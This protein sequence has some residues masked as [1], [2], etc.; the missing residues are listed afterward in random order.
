MLRIAAADFFVTNVR[1]NSPDSTASFGATTDQGLR[2]LSGGQ[3]SIQVEG[4]LAIQTGAAP[5]LVIDTAHAVRD[6]SAVVSEAPTADGSITRDEYAATAIARGI[7]SLL[8]FDDF[9]D[10]ATTSNAAVNGF[11]LAPLVRRV[12]IGAGHLVGAWRAAIACLVAI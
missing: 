6:I 10:G 9:D 11:G 7:D 1:G 2:T 5:P 3:F 12:A 8:H 4:Y